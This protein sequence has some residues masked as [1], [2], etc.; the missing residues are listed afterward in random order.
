M[1]ESLLLNGKSLEFTDHFVTSAAH[2]ADE[3]NVVC[4]I[5]ALVD[6]LA[7]MLARNGGRVLKAK[8]SDII[9]ERE[10]RCISTWLGLSDDRTPS[11]L[12]IASNPPD[13]IDPSGK[14]TV[15]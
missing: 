1:V 6:T 2:I 14:V 13:D 15:A 11:P 8:L 9:G 4:E 12:S 5:R 3:P 7:D 10:A